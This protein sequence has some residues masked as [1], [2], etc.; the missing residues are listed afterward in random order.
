MQ[1]PD[2]RTY[3]G[4]SE[5]LAINAPFS[6]ALGLTRIGIYHHVLPPWRRTS[7]PHAESDEEEFVYVISG[8]PSLWRNGNLHELSPGDGVGFP[9]GSGIAH[10]FLN[11]TNEDVTLLVVG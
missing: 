6:R 9:Q 3:A 1:E 8:R 2:N 11:T 7:Y 10:T 5:K 4:S